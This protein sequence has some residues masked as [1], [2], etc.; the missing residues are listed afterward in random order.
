MKKI[1]PILNFILRNIPL[2]IIGIITS[3]LPNHTYTTRIRGFL[4]KPF[5]KKCG[6]GFMI[7]SGVVINKPDKLVIGDNVYIA[8]NCWIN[9]NGKIELNDNVI[10]GGIPGK[11]IG[12]VN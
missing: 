9:A 5:F 6:K 3:I 10:I 8:H 7:A 2:H 1:K 4:M 11:V 12:K